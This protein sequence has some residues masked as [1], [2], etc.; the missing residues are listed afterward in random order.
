MKPR[1]VV[2]M[3]GG[4]DSSVAAALLVEQGYDVVGVMLRLWAGGWSEHTPAGNRCC[5]LDAVED[6]RRLADRFGFPFY[7]INAEDD[8]K[9]HVV[10][11]F[12]AEY[13]AGRTPNPCTACNHHI[14]FDFLLRRA[15]ALDA[16]Y[17]ATG[18]YAR[19]RTLSDGSVQLLRAVD[20][21]KDQ[22]YML[23]MLGQERLR[24]VMFP[25]GD[26][27][28][29]EVRAE[30]E[31]LGLPMAHKK[32]SQEICFVGAD[33][34]SFLAEHIPD[35]IAEG[36][37]VDPSG[38]VVGRHQGL[39]LYTIGQRSGLAL[40]PSPAAVGVGSRG[41]PQRSYV[42]AMDPTRNRITVGPEAG[43]YRA[44]LTVHDAAFN[45]DPPA[46][47][48]QAKIRS[49]GQLAACTIQR[50]GNSVEVHFEEPQRAISPGQ[51]VVFYDGDVVLGGG[52]IE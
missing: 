52:T 25:L 44:T 5:S 46:H 1:V 32:D 6:A 20:E 13:A 33:Y 34:R 27:T 19:L 16:D 11:Y 10:D 8:F 35:A 39:P 22:S 50:D 49:H 17:L 43:L 30:A 21:A 24:Q 9:T 18:H 45:Q 42:V 28:K 29:G 37:L 4:V 7:L 36:E 26:L 40:S 48:V 2:A 47:L 38:A 3:S 15:M 51:I 14:K 41:Q 12:L 23:Y 31:R